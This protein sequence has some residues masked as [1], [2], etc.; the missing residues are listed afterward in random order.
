MKYMPYIALVSVLWLMRRGLPK[1]LM[2]WL[3]SATVEDM[4]SDPHEN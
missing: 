3:K 2:Q 1:L 4:S